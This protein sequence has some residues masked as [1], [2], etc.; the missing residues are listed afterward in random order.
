[1]RLHI[2][3]VLALAVSTTA[4]AGAREDLL[5]QALAA[6]HRF[7]LQRALVL[8]L[9]ADRLQADDPFVLQKI[10]R[11]Y[12]DLSD[13][14]PTIEERRAQIGKALGYAQRAAGLQPGNAVNVLSLA[15]CHGKLAACS[16]VREKIAY[17]RMVRDEA[18]RALALDPKYAWASHVLGCWNYE[19]ASLNG[20]ESACARVFYGGLPP[21]SFEAAIQMLLRSVELDP[22]DPAHFIELGFAYRAAGMEHEAESEFRRGLSM[23]CIEAY[24]KAAQDRARAALAGAQG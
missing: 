4:H 23:P 6:E 1:M 20:L 12:S 11:Q 8:Y 22:R 21:A 10:A 5:G 9:Q 2:L 19:V 17:S 16:D 7:D 15:I 3:A 14:C 24:D 18:E 13:G